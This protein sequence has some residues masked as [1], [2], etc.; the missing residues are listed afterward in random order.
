MNVLI[1]DHSEVPDI[2]YQQR[3]RQLFSAIADAA[4]KF[5]N[6]ILDA[7][8]HIRHFRPD[9]IVFDWISDCKPIRKLV[10]MLH[11]MKPDVAMFHLKG[12]SFIVTANLCGLPADPVV[13]QWL[14]EITSDWIRARC[15]SA[16]TMSS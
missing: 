14:Q 7:T 3:I 2:L 12:D 9:V 5:V 1:Y 13:P 11:R 4:V 8:W 15:A 16:P 6:G 10:T